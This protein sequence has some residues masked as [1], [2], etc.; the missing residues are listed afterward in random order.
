MIDTI[1]FGTTPELAGRI[2]AYK[3]LFDHKKWAFAWVSS[4]V[5]PKPKLKPRTFNFSPRVSCPGSAAKL[6]FVKKTNARFQ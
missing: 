5:S 3:N 4:K 6:A 1:F 2:A